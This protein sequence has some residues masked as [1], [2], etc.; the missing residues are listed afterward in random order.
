MRRRKKRIKMKQAKLR[1]PL[2]TPETENCVAYCRLH[3]SKMTLRQMK[4]RKCLTKMCQHFRPWK[5]H[6]YWATHG[7]WKPKEEDNG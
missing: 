7:P 6:T 1:C 5:Q 3:K 2:G 4:N